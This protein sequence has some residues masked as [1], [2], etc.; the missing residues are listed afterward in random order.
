[1]KIASACGKSDAGARTTEREDK[2]NHDERAD[3][4]TTTRNVRGRGI[5]DMLE[6]DDKICRIYRIAALYAYQMPKQMLKTA[7]TVCSPWCR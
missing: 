2:P 1:M 7:A 6:Q 4:T 5:Y 3:E